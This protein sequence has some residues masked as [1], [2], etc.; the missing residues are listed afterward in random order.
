MYPMGTATNSVL[1]MFARVRLSE[2][3]GERATAH[4]RKFA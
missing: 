4:R 2:K 1:G 3:Q